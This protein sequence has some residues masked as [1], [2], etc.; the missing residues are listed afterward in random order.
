MAMNDIYVGIKEFSCGPAAEFQHSFPMFEFHSDG[1]IVLKTHFRLNLDSLKT[2]IENLKLKKN[3]AP[4]D[5]SEEY[6]AMDGLRP[7][8]IKH[9]SQTKGII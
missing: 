4:H 7:A 2:R 6:L 3:G 9:M 5:L 8:Y 1:S